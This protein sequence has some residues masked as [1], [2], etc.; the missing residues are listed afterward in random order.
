VNDLRREQAPIDSAAWT[1][2][3]TEAKATLE[4]TLAGRKVADFTGPVG[5][6]VSSAGSGRVETLSSG[7]GSGVAAAVR[8]V[9]PLVEL[10]APFEVPRG[11]LDA[12]AHGAD[13]PDLQAIRDA[14]RSIALAE[15]RV[16]FDGYADARIQGIGQAAAR[17]ALAIPE[18]YEDYPD[19]V[20]AAL[21]R[22]RSAGVA[23]PYAIAL[24]P[25]CYTGLQTTT[26]AGYPVIRHVERLLDGPIVWAPALSGAV[27]V[28]MRGG[29]FELTVGRDLSV[30][31]RDHGANT[32]S[33][34]IEE[35]FAFRVRGREP[36]VPLVYRSKKRDG[37]KSGGKK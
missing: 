24:G 8:T 28:S 5:W 14:A 13:D 37:G 7:S 15:D 21:A 12:I 30:G 9:Q 20:A 29:D 11:E 23:G 6:D 26:S 25:R 33:L 31:H 10:R 17:S 35:S 3:D 16:L 2:I 27:V 32:V 4:I 22:L 18:A 1:A 36:A 34:Y 19:I